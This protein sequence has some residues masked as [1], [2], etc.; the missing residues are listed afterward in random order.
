MKVLVGAFNQEKALVGAFSVIVQVW[1]L[2]I[3]SSNYN[4]QSSVPQPHGL[5]L[6]RGAEDGAASSGHQHEAGGG[7]AQLP[8]GGDQAGGPGQGW[9]RGHGAPV[10]EVRG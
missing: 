2:I 8:G 4:P 6:V 10:A 5:L 1:R 7:G 3:K 9:G